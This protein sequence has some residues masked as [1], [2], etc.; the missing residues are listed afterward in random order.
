[1]PVLAPRPVVLAGSVFLASTIALAVSQAPLGSPLFFALAAAMTACYGGVL[2]LAR[3]APAARP[4]LLLAAVLLGVAFRVPLAVA[5]VGA[6]SD[7]IRYL[8]DGRVQRMGYNPYAVVPADAAMAHTHTHETARMPSLRARTPYPPA[9]QLFFRMV[10]SV[11]ESARAMKLA[12]VACDVLTIVVVW[13]WLRLVGRNEWLVLAYVWN[14]LVVLEVAH[15]GHIDALGALWIT[16]SAYWLARHRRLLATV[17]FV[18]AIAT[19]F[20]PIVLAPLYWRRIG[21]REGVAGAAVLAALYLPFTDGTALSLGAVPNVVAF[22]RF[23]GPAFKGLAAAFSPQGAAAAAVLL[24]L[25]AAAWARWRLDRNDPAAWAWPMAIALACAPVVY[26]WYLLY[27]TP[28]LLTTAT[29]PLVTWTIS[30]IPV[31]VVWEL[32][33]HGG[34]WLVPTG[35]MIVEYGLVV[36]AAAVVVASLGRRRRAR[37]PASSTAV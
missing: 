13:R 26:P 16:A 6:D 7:M 36:C 5:P 18:L 37:A 35:V 22:I 30:V 11:R 32:A 21:V 24:G 31:Y 2:V 19:K 17:A 33:R 14:P 25:A 27:F 12:L 28:F 20:L 4:R 1:V 9:A 8:W 34:R 29:L 10:V 15:S 3:Q 23:N